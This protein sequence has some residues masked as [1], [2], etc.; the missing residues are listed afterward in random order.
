VELATVAADGSAVAA[1]RDDAAKV[2]MVQ[3]TPAQV[4]GV[5]RLQRDLGADPSRVLAGMWTQWMAAA[6]HNARTTILAATTLKP[7]IHQANAVYGAMMPQPMLRFLL[8][9]EPGTGK[10]IMAGMYLR[11]MQ[12]LGLIRR[13]LVVA[14]AGLVSKWQADFDR[15]FGGGLRRITAETVQ[16][17]ALDVDH[18][19]WI[20][21]LE[22]AAVNGNVQD[23]LRPELAGWDAVVFDEAHRLT[24][25]ATT[26][27]RVGRLLSLGTPRALLMTATPHRGKE[28]YFRHLLHLVD[29]EVFPDPGMA[30]PK[31]GE[32]MP[33]LRPGE[34]HYLR[35]MKES[36]VHN[37]GQ[38][39]LFKG[40][41]AANLPVPLSAV[42]ASVY[43]RALDMVDAFFQPAAQP[44]ARMVYGK[45]AAST[46]W[47][48]R[49]TLARRR[50]HMGDT[51]AVTVDPAVDPNDY[52]VMSEEEEHTVT[53]AD[54]VSGRA[55]RKALGDLIADV[56][57]VLGGEYVPSKWQHLV[58][59]VLAGNGIEPG[60]GE[61]AVI[62]TEYADS[63]TWIEARLSEQG[64]TARVYSGRLTTVE[65][66]T[67]REAFMRREYQIIVSTDAGNEGIDLQSAHVLANYDI[68]WSLV[69]LEQRMGR[70][71]R[72]GQEQDVFLYNLV[73]ADTR[74]GDTLLRLLD[75]FVIAANDMNGQLFDS[76]SLVA[77]LGGV[78]MEAWLRALYGNDEPARQS[79]LAAADAVRAADLK[80]RAETIRRLE[81]ETATDVDTHA[82]LTLMQEDLLERINPAIVAEYLNRLHEAGYLTVQPTAH[83][84]DGILSL[85]RPA[86]LPASLACKRDNGSIHQAVIATSG[87]ILTEAR[88]HVA[89]GGI[90]IL[91][92]GESAFTDLIAVTTSEYDPDLYRGGAADD[93]TSISSY[94]L[95]AYT[96][97]F[98]ETGGKRTTRWASLIRVDPDGTARRVRWETLANLRPRTQATS[99]PEST[100]TEQIAAGYAE[101][102]A[103]ADEDRQRQ[104]RRDWYDRARR[105]L[106]TLPAA[107]T[108]HLPVDRR[109]EERARIRQGIDAR[110]AELEHL[111]EVSVTDLRPVGHLRV[112]GAAIPPTVEETNSERIAVHI[113]KTR[114]ASLGY[115]V[116]DVQTHGVGY[117]LRARKGPEQRLV[118]VKGV[119]GSATSAGVRMTGN[120][121]LMAT[122]HRSDYWLYVIDD[123]A[124]GGTILGAYRDPI[125]TLGADLAGEAIIKL[126]GRAF[127]TNH[128]EDDA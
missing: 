116:D 112:H 76:L 43:Q 57:T 56:D 94:D 51:A 22:L 127:R 25:T 111:I 93:I 70:I 36:L 64:Y 77:E 13:A 120:E 63:A 97:T 96:A 104:A 5:R 38:T 90:T 60:N 27:M 128:G 95:Y 49:E 4:A 83:G 88:R 1:V 39:K 86:G 122:Q 50:D 126:P 106:R 65:R 101:Q 73:A 75:N 78:E 48:L 17:H 84:V 72:V 14:P 121:V 114:L 33:Q 44:L 62:F 80:A 81:D 46:L 103:A 117:D 24:P 69:R 31:D 89:T 9:D 34:V 45:R 19:M 18:D 113:V 7:Y 58:D 68:P 66:D 54:S 71:H 98:H 2:R 23:A 102:T 10:T 105:R 85:T 12:R 82:A 61:Q 119:W 91:G 52:D 37:D 55:E 107:L 47:A 123:C 53:H 16:Q 74:E 6:N 118:E 15:F 35:R 109:A 42:E 79:A 28:W 124:N 59:T 99:E 108:Q 87:D 3:L 11:E 100:L 40:R 115:T 30:A 8:A 110:L 92:P 20:V 67:V 29:P 32:D 21:S 26:L 125:T 41:T